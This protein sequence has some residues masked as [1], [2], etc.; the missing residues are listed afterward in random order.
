M[1]R[2]GEKSVHPSAKLLVLSVVEGAGR[3]DLFLPVK[4]GLT[5]LIELQASAY[6]LK[7]STERFK[8][9]LCRLKYRNRRTVRVS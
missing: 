5:K 6:Y 8:I 1:N 2:L 7:I 4:L 9:K 3:T